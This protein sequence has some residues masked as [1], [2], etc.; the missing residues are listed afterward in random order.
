MLYKVKHILNSILHNLETK[1]SAL[2]ASFVVFNVLRIFLAMHL[3]FSLR[4]GSSHN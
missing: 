1:F 2:A 4:T 3:L